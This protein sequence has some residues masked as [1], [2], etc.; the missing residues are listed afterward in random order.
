MDTAPD[1]ARMILEQ[2]NNEESIVFRKVLGKHKH[3]RKGYHTIFDEYANTYPEGI[4][5]EHVIN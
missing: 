5:N 2:F 3:G 4:D 1:H